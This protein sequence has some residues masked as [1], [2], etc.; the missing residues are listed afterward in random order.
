MPYP[1]LVA[2]TLLVFRTG[3]VSAGAEAPAVPCPV[4]VAAT[5]LVFR[6]GAAVCRR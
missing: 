2:A 3:D 1:V 6:T 5:L 4:P